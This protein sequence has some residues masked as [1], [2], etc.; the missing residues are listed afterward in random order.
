METR[1]TD[2]RRQLLERFT[3]PV[4]PGELI[5]LLRKVGV[6]R[7]M[8]QKA[9]GAKSAEVVGNWAAGRSTPRPEHFERLD[10]LRVVV[11]FL[12]QT[13]ALDDDGLAI[14]MWLNSYPAA[15]PFVD[16]H[17]RPAM[18]PLTA[19]QV[20]EIRSVVDAAQRWIDLRSS[21][22]PNEAGSPGSWTSA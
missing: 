10:S 12:L 11:S 18:T 15:Q 5:D 14:A 9:T 3:N 22:K 21:H 16:E 1:C 8:I 6:T 17:G 2:E 19:I 13:N 7:A 20:G 4:P